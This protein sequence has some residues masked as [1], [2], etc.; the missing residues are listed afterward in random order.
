MNLL[1]ALKTIKIFSKQEPLI[2]LSTKWGEKVDYRHVL[3]E[4]PRPYLKRDSFMNLNGFWQYSITE[5]KCFPQYFHEKILV[6]FSPEAPLSKVNIQLK[7]GEYLWY[8][9]FILL[10]RKENKK[11]ILHFGA[12]D[13]IAEI[14]I[15]QENI[16]TH[17]GGYLP[18][19]IDITK[20]VQEGINDITVCVQDKSEHGYHA[21]GKQRLKRGGMYY[22]AQSGIWQTVWIEEV[23]LTY[24]KDVKI[25]PDFDHSQI[26]L[27]I[28]LNQA[29]DENIIIEIDG[30]DK[31]EVSSSKKVINQTIK[32]S[33]K[34]AWS[35]E[36]PH[37]YN[38]KITTRDDEVTSYFAMRCF[39]IENDEN[40]IPRICLNH[41]PIFMN[42]VLDQGY[43]P[44]GLY[45]APSD[46][47]LIYDIKMMKELGFNTIRKHIKIEAA[48]WYYHCDRLGMIVWQD[49]VN[50]GFRY[51][52]L[53]VTYLPTV[54]KC[55]RKNFSDKHKYLLSRFDKNSRQEFIRECKNTVDYLSH[56]PCISTWVLFNE[57]W[58]Q[59]ETAK[60]T[61]YL[62]QVDPTR[63]IDSASGWFDQKCGDFRSEHHYFDKP[64][65]IADKRAFVIS[66]YGGLTYRVK[67]HVSSN[68]IYGYQNYE[69]INEYQN[70]YHLLFE[71]MIKP[72]IYQG[73]C[74][75]IYTQLSDIEDEI[76]GLLTYDRK[77]CKLKKD[78][79]GQ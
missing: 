32:I 63:L 59:F 78:S 53:I 72:L 41:Q 39:T 54:F 77:V 20:Y 68:R 2:P 10:Q 9:K 60:L 55:M 64:K 45:T 26:L 34:I 16:Y 24:I 33:N 71:Q 31:L 35:P 66:E 13:Q 52:P 28:F 30:Q 8:Q 65:I 75:A 18:F 58:G 61:D 43:W 44:D 25:V 23:P 4:Y 14:Y 42:G 38:I 69:D 17:V 56:F 6:P 50:S 57:G 1:N 73:L 21:K 48:R 15:N 3:D 62:R 67:D 40:N 70:N 74:G 27:T 12:V 19:E 29:T 76:N 36:N 49:M 79:N 22:T 51:H 11:T 5:T 37:L 47:A 46:E 7:P